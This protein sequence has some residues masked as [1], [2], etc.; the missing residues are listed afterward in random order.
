MGK[1]RE[2]IAMDYFDEG[3]NCA[4]AVTLAFADLLE[5]D[6]T[7]LA[8]LSSSFGGGFSRMREICGAVSGMGFVLGG[9]FGYDDP[10]DGDM[11]KA[12]YKRIQDV[13]RAFEDKNGS[14]V[15][16]E[17]LGL[18]IKHDDPIPETRTQAYKKK[19]PCKELVGCA[20]RILEEYLAN[21]DA[22]DNGRV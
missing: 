15:C 2:E 13:A 10:K 14:I 21:E 22:C 12:H 9:L 5:E 4:Q 8:K 19:R 7:S 20:A 3:Y 18:S 16:R 1:S 17:L 11:K 6:N